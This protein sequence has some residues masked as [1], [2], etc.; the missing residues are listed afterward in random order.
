MQVQSLQAKGAKLI[1]TRAA[2]GLGEAMIKGA[3]SLAYTPGKASRLLPSI[4]RTTSSI[5]FRGD[6]MEDVP[7]LVLPFVTAMGIPFVIG[8][9]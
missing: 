4:R 5:R 1:D 6:H 7:A 9:R 8:N 2:A 3:D